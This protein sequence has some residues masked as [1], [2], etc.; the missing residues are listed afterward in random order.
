[1]RGDARQD[2]VQQDERVGIEADVAI[3]EHPSGQED[4]APKTNAHEP[5]PFLR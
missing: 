5:M 2:Q 1:M 4:Q 3:A